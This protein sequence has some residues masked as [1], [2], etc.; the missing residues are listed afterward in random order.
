MIKTT[1]RFFLNIFLHLHQNECQNI[2]TPLL[3]LLSYKVTPTLLEGT[4]VTLVR[5][6]VAL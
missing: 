2:G 3:P 6:G 1:L 4:I 5:I